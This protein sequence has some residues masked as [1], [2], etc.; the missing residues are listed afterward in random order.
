MLCA[1]TVR[2]QKTVLIRYVVGDIVEVWV[3][4]HQRT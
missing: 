1:S 2:N 4:A 3:L